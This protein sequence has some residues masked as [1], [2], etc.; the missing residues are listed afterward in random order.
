ML[1]FLWAAFIIAAIF[2]QYF[3][4]VQQARGYLASGQATS[5]ERAK[6]ERGID[7]FE[8]QLVS[9]RNNGFCK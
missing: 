4:I 5:S 7:D 6:M 9:L 1:A 8:S 3:L 2:A